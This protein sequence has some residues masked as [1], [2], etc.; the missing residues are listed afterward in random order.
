M[1]EQ[2]S[3]VSLTIVM[4]NVLIFLGGVFMGR[5]HS[6]SDALGGAVVMTFSQC[7]LLFLVGVVLLFLYII[8]E[9]ARPYLSGLLKTVWLSFGIVLLISV[10]TCLGLYG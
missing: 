1:D 4:I 3:K 5:S 10:P 9:S 6:K 8:T 7:G 2:R